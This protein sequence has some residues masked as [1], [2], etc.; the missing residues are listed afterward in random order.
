M[1]KK[2]NL[3]KNLLYIV[4]PVFVILLSWFGWMVKQKYFPPKAIHYH[5][6]FIV[7]KDNKVVDFSAIKYMHTKPCGNTISND[8]T[9]EE[10]QIEKAHLH[11]YI[12]DVVHVHR[13][14]AMWKDLFTNLKYPIDYSKAQ[15]YINGQKVTDFQNGV[16]RPYDSLVVFV[17]SH[18]DIQ[19]GLKNAVTKAHVLLIEK[20]S[21]NCGT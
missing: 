2:S 10:E 20:R 14:G 1:E 18:N 17:G 3:A 13:E 6:G 8:E 12:G 11:D 4:I 5:A 21:D 19:A 15:G 9:P 16:I 7:I